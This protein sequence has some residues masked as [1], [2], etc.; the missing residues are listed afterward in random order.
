[1]CSRAQDAHSLHHLLPSPLARANLRR[2]ARTVRGAWLSRARRMRA[3]RAL[4]SFLS[5]DHVSGADTTWKGRRRRVRTVAQ[6]RRVRSVRG[7]R[8]PRHVLGAGVSVST[9]RARW[10]SHR[11]GYVQVHGIGHK[12][13]THWPGGRIS[14]ARVR[15][16]LSPKT[17]AILRGRPASRAC[18]NA[19][20]RHHTCRSSR[21]GPDSS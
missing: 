12:T 11:S 3:S 20:H 4:P 2:M 13:R 5:C 19:S 1:M 18:T 17:P 7:R 15:R 21:Q 6:L 10:C 14:C 9:D 16:L 8:S